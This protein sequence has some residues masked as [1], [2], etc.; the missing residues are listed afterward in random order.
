MTT[1]TDLIALLREEIDVLE[2]AADLLSW[3]Y[4]RCS[5]VGGKDSYNKEDEE[6]FEALVGRFAR[7]S[8]IL[9]QKFFRLLDTL[10]L[11]PTGTA[12]DRINQAEKKGIIENADDFIRMRLLRNRITHEYALE[13]ISDIYKDVMMFT[14]VLLQ[15]ALR[16]RKY[17]QR[18]L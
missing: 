12:R 16:A 4:E 1:Q 2:R 7:L 17:A 11:E 3:S 8:D 10:D 15:A 13:A 18:Y 14:P 9:V 6:R 5:Q